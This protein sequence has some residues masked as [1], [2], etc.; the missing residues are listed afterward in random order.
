M[1]NNIKVLASA[2]IAFFLAVGSAYGQSELSA[3]G[4][5]GIARF[6][7]EES[8]RLGYSTKEQAEEIANGYE[9]AQE[10]FGQAFTRGQTVGRANPAQGAINLGI[11]VAR[12]ALEETAQPEQPVR[13]T[14]TTDLPEIS[15]DISVPQR[16]PQA[17]FAE[18][19]ETQWCINSCLS[20]TGGDP[21]SSAYQQCVANNC[22]PTQETSSSPPLSNAAEYLV[23][24][25]IGNGCEQRGGT[26]DRRGITIHDL[27]GDGRDDLILADEWIVCNGARQQSITCGVKVCEAVIYVRRGAILERSASFN[28][29]GIEVASG[30]RPTVTFLEHN[31]STFS[32]GWNGNSFAQR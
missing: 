18:T 5:A 29:T 12:N 16:E 28:G 3:G 4:Y 7:A 20:T 26:F 30:R 23:N 8:E 17:P 31:L 15:E 21:A 27:D 19:R 14:T 10:F 25:H 9:N 11:G 2:K 32:F 22:F 24:Q 6:I 13:T 1:M